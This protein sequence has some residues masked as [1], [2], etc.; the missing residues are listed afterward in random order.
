MQQTGKQII[1]GEIACK[2]Y[3]KGQ[4]NGCSYCEY[5]G[6][7]GFDTRVDGFSYR[8]LSGKMNREEVMLR[9]E[10]DLAKAKAAEKNKHEEGE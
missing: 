6:I 8:K 4:E 7:C 10:E 1:D 2:P 3:R 9:M 5:H